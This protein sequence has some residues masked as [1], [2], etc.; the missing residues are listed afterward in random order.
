MALAVVFAPVLL[1]LSRVLAAPW[2]GQPVTVFIRRLSADLEIAAAQG[3]LSLTLLPFHAWEMAY[4]IILT[5]VRLVVTQRRLLEWETAASVAAS[6]L[7]LAGP[8]RLRTFVTTMAPSLWIAGAAGVLATASPADGWAVAL[9]FVAGWMAAPAIAYWLSQPPPARRVEFDPGERRQLRRMARA[10]WQFFEELTGPD[11]HWLPPD[12]FQDTGAGQLAERTSPTNIGMGLLATLAAHD[13]GFITTDELVER[14]ER[15]LDTCDSLERHEG[16]LLNWYDTRTLAPLRPRYVSTVDS[17]NLVGTLVTL[18]GGLEEAALRPQSQAQLV[19]GLL[20]TAA[21]L[22]AAAATTRPVSPAILPEM[23]RLRAIADRV[24]A[25]V[26]RSDEA[27]WPVGFPASSLRAI[28]DGLSLVAGREDM[29]AAAVAWTRSLRAGLLRLSETATPGVAGRLTELAARCRALADEMPFGFLYDRTRQLFSIG[30]RVDDI[31]GP[32]RLD[33]SYYDLLASEARLASFFAIARGDVPQRHW[34]RL[35]RSAVSIAGTPVLLSWSATMFEYLMPTLLMRSFAGTLLET[36]NRVAVDRQ[37]QY[38]RLRGVPWGISESAY[39]VVDRHDTYQYKAFGVPGLGLKRGLAD[40]LVVAPYA[41]ALALAIRPQAALRN[42][43]RLSELGAEGRFGYY[44]AVDFTARTKATPDEPA[45]SEAP[46][47]VVVRTWM[48]HHQGMILLAITNVLRDSVMVNRFH[49]D[50]RVQAT[51]LL[52]QERVPHYAAAAPPR[53]AEQT[54]ALW[55]PPS[56]PV[57]RFRTPHTDHV[58]AQFLSNGTYV[59]VVTN[60]GGGHSTWRNLAVTRARR[61][62][63]TDEGSQFLYLRDVR[64][65]LV[66]SPTYLPTRREPVDYLVTFTSE[67][68]TFRRTDDGVTTQLDVVVSAE[69][70]V[71]IRRLSLTNR[72]ARLREIEVT[73]YA[74]IVLGSLEDDLA[75][76]A[77]GKLFVETELIADIS[78]LVCGRRPRVGRRPRRLGLP[79]A[80][81]RGPHAVAHR[82]GDE[83]CR[84]HRPGTI[85]RTPGRPRRPAA[86]R[87][88]RG[89]ARPG[90]EPAPAGASRARRVRAHHLCHRGGLEP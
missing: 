33:P 44:D 77:F 17:G 24:V 56:I 41:S 84:L 57:R 70:D 52:L 82:M 73:S 16:H 48:A 54:R 40:D 23:A 86:G 55:S 81:R 34:F 85:G 27:G 63:T 62:R 30:Y 37:I 67:K 39:N 58:H 60:A 74:E 18:A 51:E 12:N 68:A 87:H 28:D 64:S 31:E 8:G 1:T 3:L 59:T 49:A 53:P 46:E 32:G 89:G 22:Q 61:D 2:P 78:A 5:L 75:H 80:Q 50:S 42:L 9:P 36:T 14:T 47:G 6:G 45:T 25:D 71:E 10:T 43:T 35:G 38:A 21:A 26:A 11:T 72:S 90:D 4:A 20:D 7:G 13:L 66:W 88:H 19:A 69:D 79:R 83:P 76:P 29:P 65:G 15:A